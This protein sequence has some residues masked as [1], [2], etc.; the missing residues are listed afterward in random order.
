MQG[1]ALFLVLVALYFIF[2]PAKPYV[3]PKEEVHA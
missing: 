2:R 1:I 3:K